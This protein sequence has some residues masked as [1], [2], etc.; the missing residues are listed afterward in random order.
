[1]RILQPCVSMLVLAGA[2]LVT[3]VSLA[4]ANPAPCEIPQGT[5]PF[6]FSS[7]GN[8]LRG[9]IDAPA[10]AG[11]HPA[12][13]MIWGSGEID[14]NADRDFVSP[15]QEA[16]RRA[17]VATV[18]WDKAGMGCSSGKYERFFP[19]HERTDEALAA[20]AELKKRADIDSSRVGAWGLSQGGWV[21]PMIAV[22]N[23]ELAFLILVSGP[24]RDAMSQGAFYTANL[25][26]ESGASDAEIGA[27]RV[28][29]QRA[30]AVAIAG[31]TPAELQKVLQPLERYPQLKESGALDVTKNGVFSGVQS[32]PEWST[33]ADLLLRQVPQPTLAI[34]GESDQIVDWRESTAI[35]RDAYA[36]SGNMNL[37][38]KTFPNATHNLMRTDAPKLV[39]AYLDAMTQWLTQQVAMRPH[40]DGTPIASKGAHAGQTPISKSAPH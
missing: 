4:E 25:L 12:I 21:A 30:T 10:A 24:G 15:M 35:Y 20:L 33:S 23:P 3:R 6:E 5:K 28:I 32:Y 18:A 31:G 40:A 7:R 26:R 19:L 2:L 22:R 13:L 11:R 29:L 16:F 36:R 37:T 17:G 39:D 27:A 38:I 34:F 1:V 8:V 14:L 9:F